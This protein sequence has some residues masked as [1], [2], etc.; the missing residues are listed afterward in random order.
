MLKNLSTKEVEEILDRDETII[1]LLD[2][3]EPMIGIVDEAGNIIRINKR[4]A[5][6]LEYSKEEL[7]GT[8]Y[9]NYI[10]D[11]DMANTIRVWTDL[12]K[13]SCRSTG[14]NGFTNR[15]RTKSGKIVKLEWH[16][17]TESIKGLA[18][19]FALFRGYGKED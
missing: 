3:A 6:V 12:N 19:S 10:I 9:F 14:L 1:S 5:E 16:A 18:I 13:K 4:F 7:I 15:Y 11:E 8:K 17:N 2:Q